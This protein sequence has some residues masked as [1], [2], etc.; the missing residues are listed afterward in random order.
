MTSTKSK[1]HLL[2]IFLLLFAF[3]VYLLWSITL[4]QSLCPDESMRFDVPLYI[5]AEGQ[6]PNGWEE[7]IRNLDW[8]FSYAF[9]VYGSSLFTLPFMAVTSLFTHNV[10]MLLTAARLA[11]V[12]LATSTVYF[13][14][15]IGRQIF[16]NAISPFLFAV[17]VGFLP[18][19]AFLASYVN[20]DISGLF[21]TALIA[22]FLIRGVREKWPIK[23]AIS[24]GVS[25]GICALSYYFAYGA[26][27]VSIITYYSTVDKSVTKIRS[28]IGIPALI[29]IFALLVCSWFFIRNA[30]LYDGDFLGMRTMYES[31]Q[32]FAIDELKPSY[33][34][35]PK[36]LGMSPLYMLFSS[37]DHNQWFDWSFKSFIGVFGYM[38]IWLPNWIYLIYAMFISIGLILGIIALLKDR[39]NHGCYSIQLLISCLVALAFPLILSIYYSWATDYQPQGRYLIC[40]LIPLMILCAKGY[41]FGF[42]IL[43][44]SS[45]EP[46]SALGRSLSFVV[47]SWLLAFLFVLIG[48]IIPS[49]TGTPFEQVG[50]IY[51]YVES[52]IERFPQ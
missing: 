24:L 7:S 10:N 40:A 30:L 27:V 28:Y 2:T 12:L 33:R 50:H 3:T 18:Q 15:L 20:A 41:E 39:K 45:V 16:Q 19:F 48:V 14:L 22:Y 8:G 52:F 13:C 38:V 6:L 26:I 37:P 21:A 9:T 44:G 47:I 4:P 31:G 17:F 34:A 49:C 35:T 29:A 5:L 43:F 51:P 46:C 1:E 23:I 11:N 36:N 32:Q 25:L 42:S